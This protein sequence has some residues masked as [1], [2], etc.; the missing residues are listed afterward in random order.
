MK[1][2]DRLRTWL[3]P[4]PADALKAAEYERLPTSEHP[5]NQPL[6]VPPGGEDARAMP[7]D[8]HDV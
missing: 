6:A 8:L 3:F 2:L 7:N 5:N 1:L 4:D